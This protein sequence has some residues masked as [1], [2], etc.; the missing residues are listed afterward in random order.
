M[1][2]STFKSCNRWSFCVMYADCLRNVLIS[3]FSPLIS[4]KPP[5]PLFLS[6]NNPSLIVAKYHTSKYYFYFKPANIFNKEDFPAPDGPI[7]AVSCPEWK[8]PLIWCKIRL[9]F[10]PSDSIVM[11]ALPQVITALSHRSNCLLSYELSP[12]FVLTKHVDNVIFG[13]DNSYTL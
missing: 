10:F 9:T 2:S 7:I 13:Y 1:Y 11:I 4:T 8:A 5:T 3:I 6:H 12:W